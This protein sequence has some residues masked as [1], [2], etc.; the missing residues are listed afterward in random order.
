VNKQGPNGITWTNFTW[1][2][3]RGC[4]H[5]CQWLMPTGKMANC[6]AEDVAN[7]FAQKAYPQGFEHHY[8]NPGVLKEPGKVKT[9]SKIFVGS[10]ADVFGAWVPDE[11]IQAV[12]DVVRQ[13]PQHTFQFLTK[14]PARLKDFDFPV[15]A[16][17]GI[18]A[19]PTGM[20]GKIWTT[21]MKA[22]WLR[23]SCSYLSRCNAKVRWLSAEPLS[24]NMTNIFSL[25]WFDWI[26]IG[27]ASDGKTYYQPEPEWVRGLTDEAQYLNVPVFYKGNL[28]GNP[29]AEPWLEQ[30]PQVAPQQGAL[31]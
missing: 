8:W 22:A 4:F 19:P 30:F 21:P 2:P 25:F 28:K 11:Q 20:R 29:G 27:A 17:V 15:N 23:S 26:V 14:N 12:L 3:I 10:M 6:Y 31:L 16:W 24:F 5:G 1:N 13:T 18:S 7:R 9:P